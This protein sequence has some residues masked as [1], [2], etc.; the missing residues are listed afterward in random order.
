LILDCVV[1]PADIQDR[2]GAKL[3]LEKLTGFSRLKKIWADGAYAGKLVDW[4]KELGEWVL[5]IVKRS[6]DAVGFEVLPH[7]WIVERTFAWLGRF[8]RL[9]K[10]YEALIET[11]E[12]MIRVA[13]IR[14]MIR[15]LATS[16]PAI[17]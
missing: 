4:A 8:R 1:H 3:V 7:R 16:R 15:R 5:E 10:D 11:S 9:S 13:M 6:D 14:L 12:A 2:D 17:S